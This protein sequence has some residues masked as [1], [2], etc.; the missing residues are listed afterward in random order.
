MYINHLKIDGFKNLSKIEITPDKGYNIIVGKNAQG[1][2]NILEAIW[3]M[4][5]CRSFRGSRERDYVGFDRESAEMELGFTDIQRAQKISGRYL[6]TG[7]NSKSKQFTIN[8]VPV[9]NT[10]ELFER[11][12]CVAF[13]PDDTELVKGTPEKRR[14]YVDMSYSQLVPKAMKYL[15]RYEALLTQRNILLKTI[16]AGY[17]NKDALTIWDSQMSEAGAY[18]TFMR[19]KYVL[20]LCELCKNLYRR[21]AGSSEELTLEYHS[22][23]LADYKFEEGE[24]KKMASEYYR[25]LSENVENDV[26]LGY[27]QLGMHRFE[28]KRSERQGFRLSGTEKK[29]CTGYEACAGGASFL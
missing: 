10:S 25:R 16:N 28:N 24:H 18:I 26:R 29:H 11:F 9:K 8:E 2:T 15:R 27:T 7:V 3:V 1:K 21:I 13:L 4:T 14:S 22:N 17:E 23:I 19:S 12:K 20:K 6:R 5:G